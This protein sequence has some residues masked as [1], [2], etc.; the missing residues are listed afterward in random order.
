MI[1]TVL[2][3]FSSLTGCQLTANQESI[4]SCAILLPK[5]HH[6]QI[7]IEATI[8]NKGKSP[9][10]HGNIAVTDESN[11]LLDMTDNDTLKFQE[12]IIPV[13]GGNP[14]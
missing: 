13:L 12:C 5:N 14:L 7:N 9:Q 3:V 11:H 4:E 2:G 10:L 8:R 6:Y 1:P